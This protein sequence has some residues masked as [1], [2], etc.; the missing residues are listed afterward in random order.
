MPDGQF[1]LEDRLIEKLGHFFVQKTFIFR[2]YS[3]FEARIQE[4]YEDMF[5][6][7]QPSVMHA[8]CIEPFFYFH[9]HRNRI[10]FGKVVLWFCM[11]AP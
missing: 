8:R 5:F 3:D 7:F 11:L 1:M 6:F 10:T 4:A 9:S 2:G